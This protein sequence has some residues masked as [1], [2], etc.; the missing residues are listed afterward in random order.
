MNTIRKLIHPA[1]L[2][3]KILSVLLV[4]AFITAALPQAAQ[5]SPAAAGQQAVTCVRYHTIKEGDTT[6][7]IAK[8][9]GLKW[10]EIAVANKM[11]YPY[12]LKVGKQLCIPAK[13]PTAKQNIDTTAT[14]SVVRTSDR[15]LITVKNS[16]TVRNVYNVKVGESNEIRVN[17]WYKLGELKVDKKSTVTMSFEIPKDLRTVA[18]LTV[19]LKNS[20]TDTL[21]CKQALR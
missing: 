7:T 12:E 19:C 8:T 15:I 14:M 9:Y 18:S 1:G 17:P 4:M 21:V 13:A 2:G 3:A 20:T 5:A 16:G 10:R 6:T 11:E